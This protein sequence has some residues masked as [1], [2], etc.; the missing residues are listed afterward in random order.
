M[1]RKVVFA[2]EITAM[3]FDCY[4]LG[5]AGTHFAGGPV[6]LRTM[7]TRRPCFPESRLY[8]LFYWPFAFAPI[9]TSGVLACVKPL[10][11]QGCTVM[12]TSSFFHS[13]R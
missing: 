3:S 4:A 7:L 13:R 2:L 5:A 10:D 8:D 11:F 9:V 1:F 12:V 6:A